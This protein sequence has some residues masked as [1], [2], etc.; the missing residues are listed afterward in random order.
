MKSAIHTVFVSGNSA[1]SLIIATMEKMR[2]NNRQKTQLRRLSKS[3]SEVME[4]LSYP[5]ALIEKRVN[6]KQSNRNILI[7]RKTLTHDKLF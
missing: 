2:H 6:W 4:L 3:E 5:R 1:P 7:E